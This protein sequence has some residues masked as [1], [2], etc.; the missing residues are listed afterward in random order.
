L[1][2]RL[3]LL[4]AGHIA[5]ALARG[6][7]RDEIAP[8]SRPAVACY[9]P[10]AQRRDELCAATAAVPAADA[11]A[12]VT[13]A[14]VVVLAMRPDDVA[15]A[16]TE[17]SP[18]L[19][20]RALVSVAAFVDCATLAAALPEGARVGRVMPNVAAAIGRAALPMVVGTLAGSATSVAGVFGLLGAVVEV[21]E[22][23]YDAA[24]ALSGCGP[25]F[26]AFAL[27]AMAECGAEHGLAPAA[28]RQLA[29][30]AFAGAAGLVAAGDDPGD[31]WRGV[32]VPGGMTA[33]GIEVLQREGVA[34]SMAEAVTAAVRRA[35]GR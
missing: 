10:F 30:A 34:D 4:G 6:W 7:S 11:A 2:V 31:L 17:I 5:R 32:A 28:A 18:H 35:R 19:G 8:A 25:G 23:L 27:E 22:R 24:T 29:A 3:A 9:D 26:A 16:L 12:A 21:D 15:G 20:D 1:S 14:D 33:A 13:A